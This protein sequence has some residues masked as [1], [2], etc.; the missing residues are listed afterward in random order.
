MAFPKVRREEA[1]LL[2]GEKAPRVRHYDQ[3]C[4][5]LGPNLFGILLW[6]LPGTNGHADNK[7]LIHKG[8]LDN[9]QHLELSQYN[10]LW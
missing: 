3:E 8:F 10:S 1:I 5:L 4:L 7:D 2:L 9:H 6:I